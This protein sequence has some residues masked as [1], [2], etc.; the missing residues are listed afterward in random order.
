MPSGRPVSPGRS[1]E[2]RPRA[3]EEIHMRLVVQ[4]VSRAR[5]TVDGAEVGS[6]GRGLLVLLAVGKADGLGEVEWAV[7]KIAGLRI[8]EDDC[9]RMNRSV[10]EIAGGVLVVSQFTLYGD[11][12]KGRRPA[13]TDAAPPEPATRLYEAVCERLRGRGLQVATGRFA[14]MMAVE[15]VNEGPVTILL[16]SDRAF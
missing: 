11:V 3:G 12:R 8:F 14:A 4:R 7:E 1:L 15:L 9:G 16:D 10:E 13:F 2:A 5:V 6:I